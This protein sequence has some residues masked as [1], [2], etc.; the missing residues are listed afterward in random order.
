MLLHTSQ[1]EVYIS[2]G[3]IQANIVTCSIISYDKYDDR[4][5]ISSSDTIEYT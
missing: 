2:Y 5:Q 3:A 4:V 1:N